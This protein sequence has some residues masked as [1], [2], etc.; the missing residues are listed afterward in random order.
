MGK[1]E[2]SDDDVVSM[3]PAQAILGLRMF[4]VG[5]LVE[6]FKRNLFAS[7]KDLEKGALCSLLCAKQGGGWKKGKLRV[8]LVV[9]FIEDEPVQPEKPEE[10]DLWSDIESLE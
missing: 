1:I 8:R 5:Q 3:V 10:P 6:A 2:P 9:E 7:D 4:T